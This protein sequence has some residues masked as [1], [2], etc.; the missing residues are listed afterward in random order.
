[1][2]VHRLTLRLLGKTHVQRLCVQCQRL[3]QRAGQRRIS[4]EVQRQAAEIDL[5]PVSQHAA[6]KTQA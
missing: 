3:V 2:T 4:I 1:M 6:G 5:A